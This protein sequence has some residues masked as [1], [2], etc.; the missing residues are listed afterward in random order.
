MTDA[1]NLIIRDAHDHDMDAIQAIYA[2]HVRY[3]LASW[4]VS[5]PGIAEMRARRA[6]IQDGGFPYRVADRAGEVLGYTYASQYRP[7]PAYRNTVENAIYVAE[8]A[9]GQG[10]GPVLL[11]DIVEQ[12]T[13]LGFR[14]MVAVI[15]DSENTPSIKLHE[16]AGFQMVGVIPACG[17]KSGRWLDQVLMQ[18]ALGPGDTEPPDCHS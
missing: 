17:Y 13:A 16:R 10:I 8:S 9:R 5:P 6:A 3:G 12:C 4:E 18:K 2:H 14:R 7:R 15:G 11:D 1:E